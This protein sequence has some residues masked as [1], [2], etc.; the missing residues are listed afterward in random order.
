MMK[1]Y[2]YLNRVGGTMGPAADRGT[3]IHKA[4]EEWEELQEERPL[5]LQNETEIAAFQTAMKKYHS[6]KAD[7]GFKFKPETKLEFVKDNVPVTG[8]F[9]LFLNDGTVFDWKFPNKAWNE[10]KFLD[11]VDKQAWYYFWLLQDHDPKR[12]VFYV[13]NLEDPENPQQFSVDV[14]WDTVKQ[15]L[16]QWLNFVDSINSAELMD[17]WPASP[18]QQKCNWCSYKRICERSMA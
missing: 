3:R 6:L 2:Y 5:I 11:Y 9:D 17:H 13:I 1:V 16:T 7:P 4:I 15:K 8:V 18:S 10:Y 12:M 14:C